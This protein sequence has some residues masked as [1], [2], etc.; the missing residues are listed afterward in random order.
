MR[1][2]GTRKNL[3][4]ETSNSIDGGSTKEENVNTSQS[5]IKRVKSVIV[6]NDKVS[7]HNSIGSYHDGLGEADV[8]TKREKK[9]L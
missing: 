3:L 1:E 4:M 5:V 6:E 8:T 9:R 7:S 2:K